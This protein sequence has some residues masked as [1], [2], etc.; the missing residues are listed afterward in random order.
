MWQSEPEVAGA[1]KMSRG[2]TLIELL[3]VIAIVSILAAILFPVFARARE[4]AR[5]ASCMSNLK[6]MGLAAM[7]YTQD[8][9]ET[10][11]PASNPSP[12]I[13]DA[14]YPGGKWG[15]GGGANA[16]YWP[17]LIYPY[18]KSIQLF[19]C[20]SGVNYPK[21]ILGQYGANGNVLIVAG[22]TPLKLAAINAPAS[23]YMAMDAGELVDLCHYHDQRCGESPWI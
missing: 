23:T 20:P 8:H 19:Y 22:S 6:Q 12:G 1:R 3:V 15:T 16:L 17:Q 21:P 13:A 4:N 5:R 10:C 18:S 9:D 7:M 14:D 11:P 2:F